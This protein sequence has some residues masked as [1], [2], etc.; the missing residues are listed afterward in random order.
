MLDKMSRIQK[1]VGKLT[2]ALGMH[3]DVVPV[4][5]D[6]AALAMADLATSVVKEFTSLSGVMARHY[7]LKNGYPEQV[8][9][10]N[11]LHVRISK[12]FDT[13]FSICCCFVLNK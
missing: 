10:D 12:T 13:L 1:I 2:F 9:G 4:V 8:L 3:E 5:E 7:A 6:A 11:H